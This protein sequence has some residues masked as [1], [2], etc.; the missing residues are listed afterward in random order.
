MG[1]KYIYIKNKRKRHTVHYIYIYKSLTRKKGHS[2]E[3]SGLNK[4]LFF[5][6]LIKLIKFVD[7]PRFQ[8]FETAIWLPANHCY[9]LD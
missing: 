6:E 3:L 5:C 1:Y 4:Y 7:K 8:M 2:L 9:P